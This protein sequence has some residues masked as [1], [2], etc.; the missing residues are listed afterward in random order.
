MNN[1]YNVNNNH[2]NVNLYRTN[3]N[4]PDIFNSENILF[5]KDLTDEF[6]RQKINLEK[7]KLCQV[8]K[9]KNG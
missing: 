4:S 1:Q 9:N 8:C 5:E 6:N 7:N 2:N 3:Q